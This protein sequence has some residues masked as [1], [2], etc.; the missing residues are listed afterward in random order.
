MNKIHMEFTVINSGNGIFDVH[1]QT[2]ECDSTTAYT[3]INETGWSIV[4][5]GNLDE[6]Y[7]YIKLREGGYM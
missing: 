6:C 4:H 3:R 2:Y 7:A 1:M 5:F